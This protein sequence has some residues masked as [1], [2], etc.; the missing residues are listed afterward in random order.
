MFSIRSRI[1]KGIVSSTKCG[2]SSQS[3]DPSKYH[4]LFYN[5]VPNILEKRTPY[6]SAHLKHVM[7]FVD[8][9]NL[10]LGGAWGIDGDNGSVGVENKEVDG[11]CVVFKGMTSDEIVTFVKEDPY[12]VNGLISGYR[13]RPWTVVV[14]SVMQ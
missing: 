11:A 4:V 3:S 7:N 5:Y 10:Q 6:R 14:G 12:F 13:I 1:Y 8:K 9:G 2:F